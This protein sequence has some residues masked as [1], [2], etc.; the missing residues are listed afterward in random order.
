VWSAGPSHG[1]L[2]T[3]PLPGGQGRCSG[4]PLPHTQQVLGHFLS[5]ALPTPDFP[6]LSLPPPVPFL[7]LSVAGCC[8]SERGIAH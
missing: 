5:P 1:F 3:G 6:I 2:G 4:P 8:P 7:T